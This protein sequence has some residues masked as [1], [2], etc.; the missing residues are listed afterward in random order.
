MR[1]LLYYFFFYTAPI[2]FGI[3]DLI[4][5]SMRTDGLYLG[6]Y[7][8]FVLRGNGL[9]R[10]EFFSLLILRRLVQSWCRD[11]MCHTCSA[12]HVS[13]PLELFF[14]LWFCLSYFALIVDHGGVVVM[15]KMDS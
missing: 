10:L 1:P 15:V 8:S 14:D 7:C 12:L 5:A 9:H 3:F 11:Y 2:S 6:R 4:W 13:S